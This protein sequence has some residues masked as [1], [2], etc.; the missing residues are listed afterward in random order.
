[1]TDCRNLTMHTSL[2]LHEWVVGCVAFWIEWLSSYIYKLRQIND[3]PGAK[4]STIENNRLPT[5]LTYIHGVFQ[6]NASI[7]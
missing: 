2:L 3:K 1:M 5:G 6:Q 4:W 7:C